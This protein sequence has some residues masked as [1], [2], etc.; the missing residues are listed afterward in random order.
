MSED[1]ILTGSELISALTETGVAAERA[2]FFQSLDWLRFW[3]AQQGFE[4]C[5][6]VA[7]DNK[8]LRGY[9]PFCTRTNH[10][11]VECYSMPMGTYG[12]AVALDDSG[13]IR[14][15][16]TSHFLDWCRKKNCSRINVVEFSSQTDQVLEQF[17]IRE[18]TT[19][20]VDLGGGE[21]LLRSALSENHRRNIEKCRNY[22]LSCRRVGSDC[23]VAA[24]FSLVEDGAKCRGAKPFYDFDFYT[25]LLNHIP[26]DNLLWELVCLDDKP[27][28]GHI[29]FKWANSVF[30]WDGASSGAG[31]E[32]LANFYLFWRNIRQFEDEGFAHLNLGSSPEAAQDLIRFKRGW[33]AKQVNYFEYNWSS[34]TY[35][36][37]KQIKDWL[38]R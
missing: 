11:I 26:G 38:G 22:N 10:G 4:S 25:S 30:Y 20:I 17:E 34:V 16:L 5:A 33:G 12:S 14:D 7:F 29:Y 6:V 15:L 18:L 35:R 27:C 8:H 32:A 23:D 28:T 19:Q 36:G 2:S 21:E 9:L 31:L 13:D 1:N 37:M 3:N 24:Y